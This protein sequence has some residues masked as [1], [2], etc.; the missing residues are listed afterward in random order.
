[1]VDDATFD[2]GGQWLGREHRRLRTL[3]AE[4]G[5]ATYPQYTEGKRVID[6]DGKVRTYAGT[7]PRLA[8]WKLIEIQLTMMRLAWLIRTV[9]PSA[10][11]AGLGAAELDAIS[12]EHK[13]RQWLWSRTSRE[14][15]AAAARVVFGTEMSDVSLLYFLSYVR[16][17]GGFEALIETK[18]GAQ[19]TK[20]VGG[21]QALSLALARELDTRIQTSAPVRAITQDEH[22][23]SV[24][25]A[26]A[27]HRA[28]L[29]VLAISPPL[30]TRIDFAPMLPVLHE[31]LTQRAPMGATVKAVAT[32]DQAF[33]RDAGLSG[34]AVFDRGPVSVTFD[35]TAH[36][37]TRPALLAFIVGQQA[38]TWSARPQSER[39]E[40]V[41]NAFARCFGTAALSPRVYHE[42]DWSTEPWTRG[43]PVAVL[44]TGALSSCGSA[45]RAPIGRIHLAGT[46]S[47][48]E[49]TGYLEGALE[50][51]ERVTTELIARL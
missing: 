12:L 42:Q 51:A 41:L 45:L 29:C 18:N 26:A 28:R 7:I 22:G 5:V 27:T 14:L 2:L 15:L 49:H 32:Y 16:A 21:A 3:A 36:G 48:G 13:A 46:E 25:T 47:A 31:Q 23:V 35:A 50:S 43:C 19:E 20:F 6:A 9:D 33:W 39:R 30:W 4:L 40:L 34:E 1:M 11:L 17:S 44:G 37:N 10:P 24:V 8:P 38:R